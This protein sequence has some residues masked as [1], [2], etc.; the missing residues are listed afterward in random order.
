MVVYP[1]LLH[2]IDVYATVVQ[3]RLVRV[4][5]FTNYRLAI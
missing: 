2:G 4:L 1:S 5:K 3:R